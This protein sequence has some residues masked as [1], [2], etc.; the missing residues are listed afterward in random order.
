MTPSDKL[1]KWD[2]AIIPVLSLGIRVLHGFGVAENG[3]LS[4]T[5]PSTLLYLLVT[6]KTRLSLERQHTS[7]PSWSC[8]SHWCKAIASS[9]VLAFRHSVS[10]TRVPLCGHDLVRSR[11]PPDVNDAHACQTLCP[12]GLW[13]ECLDQVTI[14]SIWSPGDT[15]TRRASKQIS[16]SPTTS[17]V[18][19]TYP[20]MT[21]TDTVAEGILL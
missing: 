16:F 19:F 4:R 18:G 5:L 11:G 2:S 10:I 3:C 14:F 15:T 13:A 20:L 8:A 6:R 21:L 1:G 17:A 12:D 7:A 9:A